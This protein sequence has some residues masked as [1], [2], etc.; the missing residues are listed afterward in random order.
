MALPRVP[1]ARQYYRAALQRF[2]EAELLL[3]AQRTT[4]ALYLAGY[5]VECL[6][7]AVLLENVSTKIR[8]KLFAAFRGHLGHNIEELRSQIRTHVRATIPSAT[9]RQMARV[10]SWSTELR[11][12][13]KVI[14]TRDAQEFVDSV[15]AIR[16]WAE[17]ILGQ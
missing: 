10:A 11:Y 14:K 8:K 2:D 6:M 13:T 12:T 17:G 3:A 1:E 5:T 4:G 16:S 15:R 7:K 9:L